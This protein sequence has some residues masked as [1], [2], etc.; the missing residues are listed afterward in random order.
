MILKTTLPSVVA[1][2]ACWKPLVLVDWGTG[3]LLLWAEN[4]VFEE[5][6]KVLHLYIE[7]VG[8]GGHYKKD[9]YNIK[10]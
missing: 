10:Q 7:P 8:A 1:V 5:K 9:T 6:L 3:S 2:A 4:N